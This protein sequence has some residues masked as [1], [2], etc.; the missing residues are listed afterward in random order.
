M[1]ELG[2]P[3]AFWGPLKF[4][5]RILNVTISKW[6]SRTQSIMCSKENIDGRDILNWVG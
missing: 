2:E 1:G 5:S 6:F 4:T 3:A